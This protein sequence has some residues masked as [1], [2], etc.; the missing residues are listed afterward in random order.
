[1]YLRLNYG[2]GHEAIIKS[3]LTDQILN[4]NESNRKILGLKSQ[5]DTNSSYNAFRISEFVDWEISISP[6]ILQ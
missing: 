3:F 1:M 5:L 2:C 6:Y 4:V